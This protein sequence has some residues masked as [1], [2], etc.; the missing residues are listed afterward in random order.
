MTS[1]E[2]KKAIDDNLGDF[3]QLLEESLD[4]TMSPGVC[5]ECGDVYTDVDPLD[6]DQFCDGCGALAV[7]GIFTIEGVV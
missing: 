4:G 3:D 1:E 6:K 7:Q 2:M 5:S